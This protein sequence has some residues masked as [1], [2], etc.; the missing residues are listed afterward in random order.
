RLL[1]RTPR[2]P[3]APPPGPSAGPSASCS[4]PRPSSAGSCCR[5]RRWRPSCSSAPAT[6]SWRPFPAASVRCGGSSAS[7]CRGPAGCS[8]SSAPWPCSS[9][10]GAGAAASGCGRCSAPPATPSVSPSPGSPCS[11][12]TRSSPSPVGP[13]GAGR[14]GGRSRRCQGPATVSWTMAGPCGSPRAWWARGGFVGLL[15]ADQLAQHVLQDAAVAVVV[16]LTGG[17]DAHHGVELDPGVGADL[18]GR[19]DAALVQL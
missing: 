19:G 15:L 16:G 8:A 5:P 14:G 3:H 6:G 4:S 10:P 7:C 12:W 1:L 13:A 17:V 11:A 18:D 2:P 9:W